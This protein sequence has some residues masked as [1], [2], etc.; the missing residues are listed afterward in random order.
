M[1]ASQIPSFVDFK[2]YLSSVQRL[3]TLNL[4]CLSLF[5]RIAFNTS[6]STSFPFLR[7]DG[8]QCLV[9][10]AVPKVV[11]NIIHASVPT[12]PVMD[13]LR[14]WGQQ[15][16]Y[17]QRTLLGNSSLNSNSEDSVKRLARV[18]GNTNISGVSCVRAEL[19]AQVRTA[20]MLLQSQTAALSHFSFEWKGMHCRMHS[21]HDA[22]IERAS[23]RYVQCAACLQQP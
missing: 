10:I 22:R 2:S 3:T 19:F 15:R 16:R 9:R 21:R 7:G 13:E 11:H 20:V 8:N 18:Q 6:L 23:A 1:R 17:E 4:V 5:F 12:S 14:R